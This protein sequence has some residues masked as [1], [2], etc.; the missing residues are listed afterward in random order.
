MD[1]KK[2]N[3]CKDSDSIL[4]VKIVLIGD[5]GVGKSSLLI[6]Y[7]DDLFVPEG[8]MTVGLDWKTKM[9][10]IQGSNI[11]LKIVD[12]AGQE[13]FSS[14]APMYCRSTDIILVFYDICK[15]TSFQNVDYWLDKVGESLDEMEVVLVGN[16]ADRE[17]E[18]EVSTGVGE[19]KASRL[20]LGGAMFFE[21]SAKTKV[22]LDDMFEQSVRR[23][24]EKKGVISFEQGTENIVLTDQDGS[25][26]NAEKKKCCRS[27]A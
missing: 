5:S 15:L 20:V 6:R 1:W 13:R 3:R 26:K 21:T 14:L 2:D 4:T 18:R 11:Q 12:T 19:A 24:L 23:V 9:L 10:H 17:E 22:N 7:V 16:K 8:N 25:A 27:T